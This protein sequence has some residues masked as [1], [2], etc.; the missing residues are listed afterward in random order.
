MKN[1]VPYLPVIGVILLFITLFLQYKQNLLAS[2]GDKSRGFT[3]YNWGVRQNALSILRFWVDNPARDKA[4]KKIIYLDY[5]LMFL[6]GS[7]FCYWLYRLAALQKAIFLQKA[8][9][10]GIICFVIGVLA[11]FIQDTAI[12]YNLTHA[13]FIDLRFLT[14]I[15][16]GALTTG[17]L[18]FLT[19]CMALLFKSFNY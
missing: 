10:I 1:T 7:L 14:R 12:L 17:G 13:K 5:L 11:D 16:W 2:V 19:G 18:I 9:W 3:K 8:M 4:V 15:K 6:Y